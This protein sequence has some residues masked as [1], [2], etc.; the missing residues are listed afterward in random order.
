MANY[1]WIT[2]EMFSEKLEEI[3]DEG[4]ASDLLA[5]PGIYEIVSEHFN[6]DV[7]ERLVD[8][9]RHRR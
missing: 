4:S 8:E 1:S 2:D 5:I 7:I 3:L 6:N 9:R